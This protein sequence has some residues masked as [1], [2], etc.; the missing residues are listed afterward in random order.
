MHVH[1]RKK[2]QG[3]FYIRLKFIAHS[4]ILARV[5]YLTAGSKVFF[6][7]ASYNYIRQHDTIPVDLNNKCVVAK[8]IG[9]RH[10]DIM[11]QLKWKRQSYYFKMSVLT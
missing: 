11:C 1:R 8:E 5:M 4:D 9:D 3:N 2:K 7:V 6:Y 10:H